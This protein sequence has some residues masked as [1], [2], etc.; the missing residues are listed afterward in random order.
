MR[1]RRDVRAARELAVRARR[2]A[3]G[4]ATV[5]LLAC[6]GP[7]APAPSLQSAVTKPTS[8]EIINAADAYR[9]AGFLVA[10][11]DIAFVGSMHVMAGPDADHAQVVVAFSFPNRQLSFARDGEEYRAAYDATYDVRA[12]ATTVLHR[13]ARSEVRVASFRETLRAEESV[14]VQQILVLPP[15][16]YALDVEVRDAGSQRRGVASER[17]VVPRVTNAPVIVLAPVYQVA[18][19]SDRETPLRAVINPRATV[20]LGR[21]T[22][23]QLYV[24]SYGPNAPTRA[25]V[26]VGAGGS[27]FFRDDVVLAGDGAVHSALLH[28]PVSRIGFGFL[29]ATVVAGEQGS[30]AATE[31]FAV[32]LGDELA[33]APFEEML[34]YL[35]FFAP[36]SRLRELRSARGDARSRAWAG[37]LEETDPTPST[38]GNEALADYLRRVQV[39][40]AEFREDALAGWLSDRGKVF[41]ALG[42]PDEIV[43]GESRNASREQASIAW[44][45][46]RAGL[47]LV[48]TDRSSHG[49]WRLTPASQ[50]VF[51]STLERVTSCHDCR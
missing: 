30:P 48:F 16:V 6:G 35:R 43:D 32:R 45:Y 11:G 26:L 36:A 46:R 4:A 33:L 38:S 44:E 12:G 49:R 9:R 23:F 10:S 21:D 41:S 15:G 27:T 22:A 13:S 5:L 3:V 40:N 29:T 37:L 42:P 24:E 34:D 20:V 28:L 19:R 2:G 14:I 31:P 17:L 7:G 1:T 18:P 47:R 39:A 25:R 51:D 8:P 50:A